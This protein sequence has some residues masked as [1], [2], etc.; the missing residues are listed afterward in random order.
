MKL[1][2][3]VLTEKEYVELGEIIGNGWGDGDFEGYGGSNPVTQRR[4]IYKFESPIEV[5][6]GEI[7][8]I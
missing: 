8:K 1:Y 3:V 7:V 5:E 2:V 6:K 4:A